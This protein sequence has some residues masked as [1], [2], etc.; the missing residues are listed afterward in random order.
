VAERCGF[1]PEGL[2]RS[3]KQNTGERRDA[4]VYGL[5][6]HEFRGRVA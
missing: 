1:Q 4:V 5:L 2:L 3:Y 6:P